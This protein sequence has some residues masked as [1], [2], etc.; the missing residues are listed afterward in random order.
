MRPSLK[1]LLMT[2]TGTDLAF[3]PPP[4]RGASLYLT[5]WPD[6]ATA[7]AAGNSVSILLNN[8]TGMVVN[9]RVTFEP[10]PASFMFT[11]DPTECPASFSGVTR[12]PVVAGGSPRERRD[13]A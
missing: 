4:S 5:F 11:P 9:D 10:I 2:E 3:T 1:G 6:L 8:T 13:T 7:T 12:W